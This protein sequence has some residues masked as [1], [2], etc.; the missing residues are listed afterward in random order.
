MPIDCGIL[1]AYNLYLTENNWHDNCLLIRRN[2]I[3]MILAHVDI[4]LFP[5]VFGCVGWL[6]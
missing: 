6:A 5:T 2:I 3:G 1:V 4:R